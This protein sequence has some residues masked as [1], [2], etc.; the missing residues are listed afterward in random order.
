MGP[1][2][3]ITSILRRDKKRKEGE[4]HVKT[5]AEI[6]VMQPQTR[7]LLEPPRAGRGKKDSPLEP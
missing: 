6:K 3:T 5:E 7:K 4:D 2:N 1:K